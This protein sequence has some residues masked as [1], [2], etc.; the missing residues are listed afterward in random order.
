MVNPLGSLVTHYCFG[1]RLCSKTS[2]CQGLH[3][4]LDERCVSWET[5]A[6]L[7]S[8]LKSPLNFT[9]CRA[10]LGLPC[11]GI[12]GELTSALLRLPI[13]QIS[14]SNF[15]LIIS[16]LKPRPQIWFFPS[17]PNQICHFQLAK[18]WIF[19]SLAL[20]WIFHLWDQSCY[21][22]VYT[23]AAT[24]S[25]NLVKLQFTLKS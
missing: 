16:C 3:L 17:V 12:G 11:A 23:E 21:I 6:M 15:W 10:P 20:D 18:P 25:L 22:L 14:H 24:A 9:I 19:T 2:R 5:H 7:Q 13:F 4:L 8:I 1:Q